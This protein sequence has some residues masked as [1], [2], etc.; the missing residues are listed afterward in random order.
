MR[1]VPRCLPNRLAP[2][3]TRTHTRSRDFGPRG[4]KRQIFDKVI[5]Q[6][7]VLP[8][9]FRPTPRPLCLF[10]L[11]EGCWGGGAGTGGARTWKLRSKDS[12]PLSSP[13][14]PSRLL[15]GESAFVVEAKENFGCRQ[16]SSPRVSDR[17]CD[18]VS[19]WLAAFNRYITTSSSLPP[20]LRHLRTP[21]PSSACV[22][23]RLVVNVMIIQMRFCCPRFKSRLGQAVL[24]SCAICLQGW[25]LYR[26]VSPYLLVR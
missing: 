10:A 5:D 8:A 18:D 16:K 25:W 24:S 7:S 4:T 2:T 17:P 22:I 1:H 12:P 13:L 11:S 3:S 9:A 21:P 6:L 14:T 20:D 26:N 23:F 19:V 15:P